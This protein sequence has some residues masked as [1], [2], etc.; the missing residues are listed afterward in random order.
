MMVEEYTTEDFIKAML[1]EAR[2]EARE[3]ALEEGRGE[4]HEYVLELF[5]KGL[6]LEEVEWHLQHKSNIQP[7]D[8]PHL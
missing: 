7:N 4:G 2:E 8:Q 3:E 6:S 1:E 5:K